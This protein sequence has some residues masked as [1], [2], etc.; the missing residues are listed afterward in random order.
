MK[1]E[2]NPTTHSATNPTK[3]TPLGAQTPK[4]AKAPNPL[5]DSYDGGRNAHPVGNAQQARAPVAL[6]GAFDWAGDLWNNVVD[7]VVDTGGAVLNNIGDFLGSVG[8]F[9]KDVAEGI[10]DVA[11]ETGEVITENAAGLIKEALGGLQ[12][13]LEAVANGEG[14]AGSYVDGIKA[15]AKGLQDLGLNA[16]SAAIMNIATFISSIESAMN[17][18]PE[19][20]P[21][22]PEERTM[23]E[24][25]YGDSI[26]YDK[27]RIK[28]GDEGLINMVNKNG[29]F[30]LGDTILISSNYSPEQRRDILVHEMM[31]VWQYQNGGADYLAKAVMSY[32]NGEA[33]PISGKDRGYYYQNDV[34]S[35]K[36]FGELTP[37]QQAQL[38]QDAF[39]KGVIPPTTP[40][41]KFEIQL[42]NTTSPVDCTDY[43]MDA[44]EMVRNG[45]GVP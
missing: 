14:I 20:R 12:G 10:W 11:K 22:S 27:V 38:I 42:P 29:A 3:S 19:S 2:I 35:N 33:D 24:D 9:L 37:D 23:L 28:E 43:V 26:D 4:T 34:V 16:V 30:V 32:V 41:Q 5:A 1:T 18:A 39:S 44:W 8:G 21:L 45:Q 13:V 31:H 36:P 40:P 15:A 6:A 25:I 7:F 17:S